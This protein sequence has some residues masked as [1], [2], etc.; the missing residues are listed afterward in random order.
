MIA[1]LDLIFPTLFELNQRLFTEKNIGL[2]SGSSICIT[3]SERASTVQGLLEHFHSHI[4]DGGLFSGY[5]AT[6]SAY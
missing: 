3:V 1:S 4:A 6:E 5:P 2:V